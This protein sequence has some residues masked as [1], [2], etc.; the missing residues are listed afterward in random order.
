MT[1]PTPSP[2]LPPAPAPD[3]AGALARTAAHHR[4]GADAAALAEAGWAVQRDLNHTDALSALAVVQLSLGRPEAALPALNRALTQ[5]PLEPQPRQVRAQ[6]WWALGRRDEAL[7]ELRTAVVAALHD[8]Q[9]ATVPCPSASYAAGLAALAEELV[10]AN[11]PEAA[12]PWFRG[13][14]AVR[15]DQEAARLGLAKLAEDQGKPDEAMAML[16][17]A[18]ERHPGRSA[19][20]LALGL[21]LLAQ[22][23][24][25]EAAAELRTALAAAPESPEAQRALAQAVGGAEAVAA[26]RRV[27]ARCPDDAEACGALARALAEHGLAAEAVIQARRWVVLTDG[28]EVAQTSLRRLLGGA[29]QSSGTAS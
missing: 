9:A 11:Q 4:D 29:G 8:P 2:L 17:A 10:R 27:V 26:W 12:A 14:L 28:A 7:A 25:A 13:A 1:T 16:R 3:I 6:A 22:D 18:C 20:H 5:A 15:G 19:L 24:R 21:R 23:R